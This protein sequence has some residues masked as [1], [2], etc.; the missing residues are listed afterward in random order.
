MWHEGEGAWERILLQTRT[1]QLSSQRNRCECTRPKHR[2]DTLNANNLETGEEQ[3][4]TEWAKGMYH[5]VVVGCEQGDF[6]LWGIFHTRRQSRSPICSIV[7][8]KTDVITC[9]GDIRIGVMTS[10]RGWK[11]VPNVKSSLGAIF[12]SQI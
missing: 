5:G 7:L 4:S 10:R 2:R 6:M 12:Y 11:I 8:F 3:A 1:S 9:Q